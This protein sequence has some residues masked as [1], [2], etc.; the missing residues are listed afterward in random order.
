[1]FREEGKACMDMDHGNPL[2]GRSLELGRKMGR[3]RGR[4]NNNNNNASSS[5]SNTK[6]NYSQHVRASLKFVSDVTYDLPSPP[7]LFPRIRGRNNTS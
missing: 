4:D 5:V 2:V 7:S 1:M 3:R 6:C